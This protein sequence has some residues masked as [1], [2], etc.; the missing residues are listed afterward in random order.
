MSTPGA[1]TSMCGPN[2][3]NGAS[4]SPWAIAPTAMTSGYAAGKL[5]PA[6][7]PALP[8]AATTTTPWATA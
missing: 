4:P 1:T 8:I 5:G 6:A 2:C 7:G 3:V